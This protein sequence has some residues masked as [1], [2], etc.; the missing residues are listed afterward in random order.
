MLMILLNAAKRVSVILLA[1]PHMK[2]MLVIST[3]GSLYEILV[4]IMKT[5]DCGPVQVYISSIHN[6]PLTGGVTA[7]FG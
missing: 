5:L 3:K 6:D 4:L 7:S 1:N 2:N